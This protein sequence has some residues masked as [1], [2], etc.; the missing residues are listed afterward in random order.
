[1]ADNYIGWKLFDKVTIV[2]KPRKSYNYRTGETETL[3]NCQGY[4]VDP[5]NKKQLENAIKW[6]TTY[7]YTYEEDENGNKKCTGSITVPPEQFTYDNDGFELELYKSAD[8]SSQGGKL[9]FWNCWI[10]APDDKKF[11]IGIAADLLLDLLKNTITTYGVV[12]D[13]LMFARC[14]NGVGMLHM[15]MQSYQD[16]VDD[17]N[18]RNKMKTGK[19]SKHVVG[20]IYETTTQRNAYFGKL[21]GWYEPVYVERPGVWFNGSDLIGFRKLS[22]P[23]EIIFFPTVFEDKTK[24]SDYF[25]SPW[26]EI[27]GPKAP[28]RREAEGVI[29]MDAS[30]QDYCDHQ[31]KNYII[32]RANEYIEC[33]NKQ[34]GYTHSRWISDSRIGLSASNESYELPQ[35]VRDALNTL[36]YEVW[37]E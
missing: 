3:E 37:E 23:R 10:T 18:I 26:G 36:G 27:K 8:G 31:S 7:E 25:D 17:S 16:A 6:A 29:E 35:E 2:A 12:Q 32:N 14:K 33:N 11:L 19:T 20:H 5:N 34:P 21:Y 24:F 15:G 13:K 1:M 28:A 4:V 30:M 22:K 9:S